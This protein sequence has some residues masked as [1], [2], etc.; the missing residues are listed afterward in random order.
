MELLLNEKSLTGQFSDA[1]AFYNTLPDFIEC[2]KI[3]EQFKV[4]L[5]KSVSFYQS[6]ITKELS[7]RELANRKDKV[8]PTERDKVR[9]FKRRLYQLQAQEPFWDAQMETVC[10]NLEACYYANGEEVSATSVAEAAVRGGALLSF[11]Q[12]EYGDCVVL[13]TEKLN[14][15]QVP[16]AQSA[17]YLAEV[18]FDGRLIEIED[19]LYFHYK[20]T[21]LRFDLMDKK[22][23]IAL[24][25]PKELETAQEAFS[26]FCSETW[27]E[28][29]KDRYFYYKQYQPSNQDN[30]FKN[31]EYQEKT[32]HKFRCGMHSQIRC[33]GF[34]ENDFF[35]VLRME[36]DHSIS[37][38]G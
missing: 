8:P 31:T 19:F 30:W 11:Q 18:L 5:H 15:F 25:E 10:Q 3:L 36:R 6:M 13:V 34:R 26:R 2:L 12:Q 33:F 14:Q 27:D 4:S 24:L 9:E 29:A 20:G 23:G 38:N 28:I 37:D 17:P 21:K 7:V 16:S 22:L 35:Y 1:L 32:I